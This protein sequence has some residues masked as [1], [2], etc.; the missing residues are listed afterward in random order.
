MAYVFKQGDCDQLG[1]PDIFPFIF[2]RSY[3]VAST[4]GAWC[5]GYPIRNTDFTTNRSIASNS[6]QK[7]GVLTSLYNHTHHGSETRIY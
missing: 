4:G 6:E 2:E 3:T 1:A 7:I 5:F